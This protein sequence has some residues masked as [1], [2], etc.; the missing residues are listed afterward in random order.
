MSV[1]FKPSS[2]RPERIR[3]YALVAFLI[4]VFLMG[5]GSRDDIT[6]LVILRPLA[7]LMCGYGLATLTRQH[8]ETN[9]GWIALITLTVMLPLLHLIPL[10]PAIWQALPG[11]DIVAEIDAATHLDGAWRPFSMTPARTWNALFSLAVPLAVLIVGLQLTHEDR[12]RLLPVVVVIGLVSALLGLLQAIG[13]G[14]GA[15]YFYRI[16][17]VGSAVGLFSNR[18]HQA[19]LL[20]TMLPLLTVWALNPRK[21]PQ[22]LHARTIAAVGAGLLLFP[23]ILV[24]GSRAG[25]MLSV[26]GAAGA[27]FIYLRSKITAATRR[28]SGIDWRWPIAGLFI[29][30]LALAILLANRAEAIQRLVSLDVADDLRLRV[31][32]VLLDLTWHYMP[33][34]TGLGSFVEIFRMHEPNSLLQPEYVNHAHNDLIELALTA[35]APGFLLLAAWLFAIGRGVLRTW[36][37]RWPEDPSRQTMLLYGRAAGIGLVL[38]LLASLPDYPLRTP[39]IAALAMVFVLWLNDVRAPDRGSG[40][41]AA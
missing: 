12:K 26:L 36:T 9:R 21:T 28:H 8:F 7:V 17:N 38:I 39:S 14:S 3:F 29:V 1:S 25:L 34:G 40:H 33:F 2:L 19:F 6:S 16:T 5:G 35:G 30:L 37:A 18:N 15:L 22:Q 20:A 27:A 11:R 13:P 41:F 10:P 24:T 32:P 4:L 31:L 23:M